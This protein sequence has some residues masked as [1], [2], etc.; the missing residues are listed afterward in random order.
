MPQKA[1]AINDI[2]ETTSSREMATILA[3]LRHWQ[4]SQAGGDEFDHFADCAPLDGD[5]IDALCERLN[6]ASLPSPLIVVS[7]QGGI[8]QDVYCSLNVEVVLVDWDVDCHDGHPGVVSIH[9]DRHPVREFVAQLAAKPLAEVIG[10]DLEQAI[11][12]AA[13]GMTASSILLSL[14]CAGASVP[15]FNVYLYPAMVLHLSDIDADDPTQAI[16]KAIQ[17]AEA[18]YLD[19]GGNPRAGL[20]YAEEFVR[21]VV[22]PVVNGEPDYDKSETFLDVAHLAGDQRDRSSGFQAYDPFPST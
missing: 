4:S 22:D 17:I 2:R 9:D 6:Y 13:L 7:V 14:F 3:A 18:D 16:T 15:K 20:V 21:Y 19:A 1:H 10:T 12:T 11:D 8:V 5:E